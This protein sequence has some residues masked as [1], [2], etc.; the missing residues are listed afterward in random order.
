MTLQNSI[1]YSLNNH[2]F[3]KWI[4]NFESGATKRQQTMQH[5][6]R[7]YVFRLQPDLDGFDGRGSIGLGGSRPAVVT[8][9]YSSPGFTLISYRRAV[10][11]D[12]RLNSSVGG[13]AGLRPDPTT[14]IN[15]THPIGSILMEDDSQ[16]LLSC[17]DRIVKAKHECPVFHTR[18]KSSER[19]WVPPH[20]DDGQPLICQSVIRPLGI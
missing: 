4:Y 7:A 5:F 1:V 19:R 15:E 11:T 17:M 8:A 9:H 14:N 18:Q 12:G 3:P 20:E 2:K 6:F 10:T 13:A 16:D